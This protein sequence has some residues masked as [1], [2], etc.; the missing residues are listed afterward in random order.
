LNELETR[1]N[2]LPVTLVSI[3]ADL[4]ATRQ[5]LEVAEL[6]KVTAEQELAE[7]SAALVASQGVTV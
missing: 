3:T 2:E 1:V 7:T 6:V 5:N 4:E